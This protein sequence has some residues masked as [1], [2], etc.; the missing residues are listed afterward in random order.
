ML[1]LKPCLTRNTE[2][3]EEGT[4][5]LDLFD[6]EAVEAAES[7]TDQFIERRACQNDEDNRIEEQWNLHAVHQGLANRQRERAEALVEALLEPGE[8]P[9][10]VQSQRGNTTL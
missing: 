1:T 10:A 3:D 2:Q 8:A 9:E 7:S 6:V 4:E 5:R